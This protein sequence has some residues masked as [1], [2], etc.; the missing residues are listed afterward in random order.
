MSEERQV[1]VNVIYNAVCSIAAIYYEW[2][3]AN[4]IQEAILT[5]LL[6]Q[7]PL[8]PYIPKDQR[9]APIHQRKT[10]L[11]QNDSNDND[12]ACNISR[13]LSTHDTFL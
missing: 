5:S 6:K 3:Q 2:L 13:N 10:E 4:G 9:K 11:L 8:S 1:I 7:F 12:P